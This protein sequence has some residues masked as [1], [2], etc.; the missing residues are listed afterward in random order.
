MRM[1]MNKFAVLSTGVVLFGMVSS[2]RANPTVTA[3]SSILSGVQDA[4][5]MWLASST[6]YGFVFSTSTG[7]PD[8]YLNSIGLSAATNDSDGTPAS[9]DPSAN[10]TIG[11]P[12]LGNG[13]PSNSYTLGTPISGG[14]TFYW[15]NVFS[16]AMAFDAASAPVGLYDFNAIFTG[17]SSATDDSVVMDVPLQ[18]EIVNKIDVTETSQVNPGSIGPGQ[19]ATVSA[20]LQNNMADRNFVTTTWFWTQPANGSNVLAPGPM[21]GNWF[22]QTIAPGTSLSGLHT[23]WTDSPTQPIGTYIGTT[24]IVGGLY[25]GDNFYFG[26]NNNTSITVAAVPEP[27]S[28]LGLGLGVVAF[29]RRR[30]R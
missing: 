7:D 19:T 24:G 22:N 13:F 20:T 8:F 4:S 12:T 6:S 21:I 26:D 28:L 1:P 11:G 25:N 2:G 17:G 9:F 14:Q 30:R 5:N 16:H 29:A 27:M 15:S 10:F 3:E 23:A 18:L